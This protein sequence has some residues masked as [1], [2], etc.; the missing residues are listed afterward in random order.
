MHIFRPS[1]LVLLLL[2]LIAAG[3]ARRQGEDRL[4]SIKHA[5]RGSTYE[6]GVYII[7][8][9]DS[10]ASIC[11]KFHLLIPDFMAMN[12]GL[13]WRQLRIGRTVRIYERLKR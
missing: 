9:G 5:Q 6:V 3:C 1:V 12:P 10:V 13:D 2:V 4:L 8:P 7:A 11:Q